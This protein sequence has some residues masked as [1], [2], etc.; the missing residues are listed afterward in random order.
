VVGALA[1]VV[2]G[3]CSSSSTSR[4]VN[5]GTLVGDLQLASAAPGGSPMG[6]PGT[7]TMQ[8]SGGVTRTATTG[9]GG[10]FSATVPAGS[11][12][13]TGQ[14]PMFIING[15]EGTCSVSSDTGPTSVR[16]TVGQTTS[17]TVE[18]PTK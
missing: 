17:I 16:V 8:Q 9:A 6:V 15:S 10:K 5:S 13:V 14:S 3:A 1:V 12:A 2:A 7:I 18:C 4:S 11:Y